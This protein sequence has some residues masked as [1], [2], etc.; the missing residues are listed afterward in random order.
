MLGKSLH[1]LNYLTVT[2]DI[3]KVYLYIFTVENFL[4]QIF[5]F[6][7]RFFETISSK[8]DEKHV[9][10]SGY[11]HLSAKIKRHQWRTMGWN[12]GL[13]HVPSIELFNFSSGSQA[14][15]MRNTKIASKLVWGFS[16]ELKILT[17]DIDL[18]YTGCQKIEKLMM[19]TWKS[20][21]PGEMSSVYL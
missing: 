6:Y 7:F 17:E 20:R 11:S 4:S 21:R 15:I 5:F 16:E 13:V 3:W 10:F 19:Q 2:H 8:T 14:V 12:R 9:W 1:L 18:P